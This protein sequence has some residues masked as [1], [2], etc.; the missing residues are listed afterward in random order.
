MSDA[1]LFDTNVISELARQRPDARVVAFVEATPRVLVSVILFHE[2]SYGFE[3]ANREQKLRLAAFLAAIRDR[4]GPK[5]I[6]VDVGIAETAGRLR[7]LSKGQGRVLTV[8]DSLIAATALAKA[9]PLAT[10]NVKD[11]Q[12]INVP[13]IDPF[14]DR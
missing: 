8:S 14:S 12:G 4:F 2:L 3:S 6:P 5:A 1:A 9:V 7:A 11:F 13:L 10:R